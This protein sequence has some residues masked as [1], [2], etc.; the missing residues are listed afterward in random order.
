VILSSTHARWGQGLGLPRREAITKQATTHAVAWLCAFVCLLMSATSIASTPTVKKTTTPVVK[1]ATTPVVK[2]TTTPVVKKATTPVVKKTTTPV[3]KKATTPVVKKATTPVVKKTTT[4]VVKKDTT[5][6]VKK[7][8]T[9]V[10]KKASVAVPKKAKPEL[11]RHKVCALTS[12]CLDRAFAPG[13]ATVYSA[14]NLQQMGY[15]TLAELANVTTGY[16]TY[17]LFGERVF[18][19]RGLKAGSF[20]N[21]KHLITIDGIPVNHLRA[22]KGQTEYGLPLFFARQVSFVRGPTSALWGQNAF[23]GMVNIQAKRASRKGF[24]G[25]A[26]TGYQFG[27][28]EHG[29]NLMGNIFHRSRLTET[30]LNLGAYFKGASQDPVGDEPTHLNQDRQ[31]SIFLRL[32]HRFTQGGLKGL[33]AGL[34][35]SRKNGGLGEFWSNYSSDKNSLTWQTLVPYLR[36]KRNFGRIVAIDTF[37]RGNIS[38]ERGTYLRDPATGTMSE[39]DIQLYGLH[40]RAELRFRLSSSSILLVGG[41]Y[42]NRMSRNYLADKAGSVITKDSDLQHLVG[43][44]AQLTTRIDF[45]AGLH[46][47]GGVRMGLGMSPG[48]SEQQLSY[49]LGA[50]QKITPWLGLKLTYGTGHRPASLKE[51]DLNW[52]ASLNLEKKNLSTDLVGD[53]A[54]EEIESITAGLVLQL[55]MVQL[56]IGYFYNR[57]SNVLTS[58]NYA[59]EFFFRNSTGASRSAGLEIEARAALPFNLMLMANAAYATPVNRDGFEVADVPTFKANLGVAYTM[60]KPINLRAF[61]MGRYVDGYRVGVSGEANLP[62][63]FELDARVSTTFLKRYTVDLQFRNL[64]GTG[65]ALPLGGGPRVHIDS[66]SISLNV[67]GDF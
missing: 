14:D 58:I 60:V 2:K 10:A 31:A 64:V 33:S 43:G 20:E 37:V 54:S 3:V 59:G 16:S 38:Q 6:V 1:K 42:E 22:G 45:L 8:T 15:Y 25:E 29:V 57:V 23:F 24:S 65:Y 5:P 47:M 62:P 50:V 9:P 12:L 35:L 7:T 52:E 26:L 66:R 55:S 46:L 44:F 32:D 51:V 67:K 21:N 56:E 13:S 53:L 19:T 30:T 41:D 34:I 63:Y 28:S 61:I 4:P 17:Q 48:N 49:R 40:T 11:T 18:E 36:Y 39:Y 27:F